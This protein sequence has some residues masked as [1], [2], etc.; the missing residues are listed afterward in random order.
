M[1]CRG[2]ILLRT[3]LQCAIN[4]IFNAAATT[5]LCSLMFICE[6]TQICGQCAE[7]IYETLDPSDGEISIQ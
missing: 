5:L 1:M 6:Y 2:G 4:Q 3:A 7:D